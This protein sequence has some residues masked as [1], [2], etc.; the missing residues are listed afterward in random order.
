MNTTYSIAIDKVNKVTVESSIAYAN[1][2]FLSAYAGYETSF[3]IG[4]VFT[5]NGAPVEV[6]V[7]TSSGKKVVSWKGK[8]LG[9]K[10]IGCVAIPE[11][12]KT[13]ETI[14]FKCK[15]PKHKVSMESNEIPVNPM[16]KVIR[17]YWDK[18]EVV[19]D[20]LLTC[21]VEFEKDCI[22]NGTTALLTIREYDRDNN[23][24][25]I[26]KIPVVVMNSRIETQWKFRFAGNTEDI[27]THDELKPYCKQY[28]YPEYFFTVDIDGVVVGKNQESGFVRFRDTAKVKIYA[29]PDFPIANAD[30]TF[31][32]PDGVR[33]SGRTDTDGYV[34]INGVSPGLVKVTVNGFDEV[35]TVEINKDD[36]I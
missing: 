36:F 7:K 25:T 16:L 2:L 15:L 20:E 19:R 22:E 9:N 12:M 17:I 29:W 6:T 23:H 30:V 8:I 18:K 11:K 31:E 26:T 5:G 35:F 4:T 32:L 3:E 14:F 28:Q 24:D 33:V 21:K 10:C 34:V 13:G 27:P 1:W